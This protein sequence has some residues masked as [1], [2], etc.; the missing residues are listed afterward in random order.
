MITVIYAVLA[1]AAI[2]AVCS[3]IL[4]VASKYM[5]VPVDEK[6]TAVRD[7]LPGANC[8]A[9]G[10]AGCDGY[11]EALASGAEEHT[12]LCIP[13]GDT[14]S[15]GISETIGVPFA[16]VVEKVAVVKCLGDCELSKMKYTY[17]G[18][19][20]CRAAKLLYN[21]KWECSCGCLGY[22]DCVAV[23]PNDAI[24]IANGVAK[25]DNK[26]CSG[27]GMCA[28]ECPNKLIAVFPDVS[29]VVVTCSSTERGAVAKNK[30][31]NA[32]IGC[33]KCEKACSVGAIRVIENLAVIDYDKCDNCCECAKVCMAGCIKIA[34][35]SGIHNFEK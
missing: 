17:E 1:L 11:A 15:R 32:C 30:C 16:D 27:C 23:C 6:L 21:G 34:D 14:V 13:G 18:V 7:C 19:S 33:K 22:G 26:K 2:G 12:N 31:Q 20:T 4:I 29:R 9:C 5:S 10:Y 8:G 3:V 24:Y 25:V 28:R 35:F